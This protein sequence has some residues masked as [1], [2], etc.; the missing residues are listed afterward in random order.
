MNKAKAV[1]AIYALAAFLAMVSI[2]YSVA[3][4]S[5]VNIILAIIALCFIMVMGFKMK[6]KLRERGLL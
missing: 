3:T 4:R 5:V 2:G 6:R 1:M